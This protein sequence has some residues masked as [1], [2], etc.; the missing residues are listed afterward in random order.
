[1]LHRNTTTATLC[2]PVSNKPITPVQTVSSA[3]WPNILSCMIGKKFAGM[4]NSNAAITSARLRSTT[5][6]R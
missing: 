2:I 1:M 4:N 6:C 3:D 5:L